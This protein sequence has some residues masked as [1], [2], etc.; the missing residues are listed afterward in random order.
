MG[1]GDRVKRLTLLRHAKSSWDDAVSRDFDR[2]LNKRGERAARAMG[3]ELRAL[4]LRFDH[5]IA[6]PAVRV[7]ETLDSF[8]A[9][10]GE[11]PDPD[12]QMGAYLAPASALLDL[13]QNSPADAESVLMVGHNSGLEDLVFLLVPD[14]VEDLERDKVEEKYPTA[15]VAEIAFDVDDWEEAKPGTGRL[16]RFIRPRDVDPALGPGRAD[17]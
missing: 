3:S 14:R 15:A 17:A 7:R 2:P 4:A 10:Y 6:S 1:I 8:G 11:L 12:F 16:V 5:L 9:T 13:V